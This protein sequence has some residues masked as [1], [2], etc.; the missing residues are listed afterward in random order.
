MEE[1]GQEEEEEEKEERTNFVNFNMGFDNYSVLIRCDSQSL[2]VVTII[3]IEVGC[4]WDLRP[5]L[6]LVLPFFLF[7]NYHKGN[8]VHFLTVAWVFT[9]SLNQ[10]I[11]LKSL[12]LDDSFI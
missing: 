9:V 4:S 12:L 8:Y 2:R 10:I 1:A 11:C 3:H 5:V 6:F 7:N